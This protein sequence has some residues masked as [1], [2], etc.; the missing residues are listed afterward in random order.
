MCKPELLRIG[1][2]I[3]SAQTSVSKAYGERL[4][5]QKSAIIMMNMS[6]LRCEH[7]LDGTTRCGFG[8]VAAMFGTHVPVCKKED[9]MF[10]TARL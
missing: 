7:T 6:Q 5:Q 1:K 9:D 4:A 3:S 8:D 10:A 2:S